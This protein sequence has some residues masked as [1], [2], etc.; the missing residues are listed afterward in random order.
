MKLRRL[1]KLNK[2]AVGQFSEVERVTALSAEELNKVIG[3]YAISPEAHAHYNY[4]TCSSSCGA[5]IS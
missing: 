1:N 2:D 3:G 5:A 4:S